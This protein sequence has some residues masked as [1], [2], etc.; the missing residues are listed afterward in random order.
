M[1]ARHDH[2]RPNYG[3]AGGGS[4]V[5]AMLLLAACSG[6]GLGGPS[7]ETLYRPTQTVTAS[8]GPGAPESRLAELERKTIRQAEQIAGLDRALAGLTHEL[9]SMRAARAADR[10]ALAQTEQGQDGQILALERQV[11]ALIRRIQA[12]S[13]QLGRMAEEIAMIAGEAS[14]TRNLV[15]IREAQRAESADEGSAAAMQQGEAFALH[16]ASYRDAA[17]AAGGWATLAE[18]YPEVLADREARLDPFDLGDFGGRYLRLVVGPY[19]DVAP[20]REACSR[21]RDAGAFCQL[22]AFRGDPLP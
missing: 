2:E 10:S 8:T 5:L 6:V 16:L 7:N 1:D 4:L 21:L 3:V 18:R 12:M 17:T 9:D 20:A 15:N 13:G 14:A 11:T 22:A 19:A